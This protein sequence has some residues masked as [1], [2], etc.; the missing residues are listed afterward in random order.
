MVIK[1]LSPPSKKKRGDKPLK[2][3]LGSIF[4]M[5]QGQTEVI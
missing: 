5:F 3:V 1:L 2:N 4:Y